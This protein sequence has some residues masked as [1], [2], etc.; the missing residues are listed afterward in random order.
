[1]SDSL[2][3]TKLFDDVA[4][5]I[6]ARIRDEVWTA[7]Q[8]IPS[9]VLLAD[10]FCVSRDTVRTAIKVLQS[11]GI[12]ISR[13]GSGTYVSEEAEALLETRAFVRIMADPENLSDL[14]HTRYILEPELACLA[15]KKARPA[16]AEELLQCVDRMEEYKDRDHLMARGFDFHRTLARITHNKVLY[17]FYQSLESQLRGLRVLD[18]LTLEIYLS[19]IE[20]HRRIA[21]AIA[22]RNGALARELMREHLRK[23]YQNYLDDTPG[24]SSHFSC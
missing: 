23:D 1:M 2:K 5:L 13:P 8:K 10:L 16:E 9:E 6:T 7:G 11:E 4:G 21:E 17:G 19:G 20:E 14:I 12:L 3:R 18:S 22:G 24:T 15:A